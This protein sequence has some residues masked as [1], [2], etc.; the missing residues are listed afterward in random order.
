MAYNEIERML[1]DDIREKKKAGSGA[2]HM[3]GKGIRSASNKALRTPY[4]FL[5]EKDRKKLHGEVEVFNMNSLMNWK[6]FQQK[7][8]ETQKMLMINWRTIYKNS[9]IMDAFYD[10]GKGRDRKFNSQTFADVVNALGCPSKTK[11][12]ASR[13]RKA[14][15]KVEPFKFTAIEPTK[16]ISEMSSKEL[17]TI[18]FNE[19]STQNNPAS[20]Q[21]EFEVE[22]KPNW[23]VQN[24]QVNQFITNVAEGLNLNYN[25]SYDVDQLNKLFTKL[26]LLLDGEENKFKIQLS[27]SE[28]I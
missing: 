2:F 22:D 18:Y 25:G 14:K 19:K 21:L 4:H 11:G 8:K 6:D 20:N 12:G 7:D 27:I 5:K 13:V 3:R 9:E 15:S 17:E 10:D 26:Q 23:S 28:E 16:K 24:L 1:K